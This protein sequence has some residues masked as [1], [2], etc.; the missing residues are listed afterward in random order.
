MIRCF[1]ASFLTFL[2]IN[3]GCGVTSSVVT[4]Y[5]NVTA[6]QLVEECTNPV[7]VHNVPRTRFPIA[8]QVSRHHECQG[9]EDMLVVMWNLPPTKANIVAAELIALMYV[10]YQ[11]KEMAETEMVATFIKVDNF[12]YEDNTVQAAF[13]EL[14]E[15]LREMK[16]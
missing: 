7:E 12:E 16:E 13:Y 1:L 6:A 4:P 5:I 14:T 11:N 3:L 9:V 15:N 8:A 2:I 10:E